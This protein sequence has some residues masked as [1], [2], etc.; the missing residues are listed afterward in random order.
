MTTPSAEIQKRSG[1]R[2]Q[3]PH[4]L[5]PESAAGEPRAAQP[6]RRSEGDRKAME[7]SLTRISPMLALL[8]DHDGSR[9]TGAGCIS[10]QG[11]AMPLTPAR[12][13]TSIKATRG[14][15]NDCG[16]CRIH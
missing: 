2:L 12:V 16:F 9:V 4:E 3:L 13:C 14:H 5:H 15:S 7:I 1:R 10:R 11:M 6:T 8:C